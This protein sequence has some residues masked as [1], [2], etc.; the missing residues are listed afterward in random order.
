MGTVSR[1]SCLRDAMSGQGT[2]TSD[3]V[4]NAAPAS[5][6][7][8]I[9]EELRRRGEWDHLFVTHDQTPKSEDISKYYPQIQEGPRPIHEEVRGYLKMREAKLMEEL[10]RKEKG[11]EQKVS[12]YV[13]HRSKER[14][15]VNLQT[16]RIYRNRAPVVDSLRREEAIR[17]G[18]TLAAPAS[19]PLVK[20]LIG[21]GR[22]AEVELVPKVQ[23]LDEL[24]EL[25]G[26][27][28]DKVR[29]YLDANKINTF[30]HSPL[31]DDYL[32]ELR[33]LGHLR[34]DLLPHPHPHSSFDPM[35]LDNQR[36]EA[37]LKALADTGASPQKMMEVMRDLPLTHAQKA[38][39][40]KGLDVGPLKRVELLRELPYSNTREL[41]L[42]RELPL[43]PLKKL[44]FLRG[45]PIEPSKK[46]E[47]MREL[48]LPLEP[49][50]DL[51]MMQGVSGPLEA[52]ATM[53]ELNMAPERRAAL[54]GEMRMHDFVEG[55][56][57]NQFAALR[58]APIPLD[59]KLE[60]LH[61]MKLTE[62]E[63]FE[64][65]RRLGYPV[66]PSENKRDL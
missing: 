35:L 50:A 57:A 19:M 41:E 38:D 56:V 24:R 23:L 1:L 64:L 58:D 18:I 31:V 51:Q 27:G 11:L 13:H 40:I 65:N 9:E 53:D 28:P 63:R 30:T 17:R 21:E 45:L 15:S 42:L 46:V 34:E 12:D 43:D 44:E 48:G 6:S 10:W 49:S 37:M 3:I 16:G 7:V 33:V 39:F 61:E 36:S 66:D 54:M 55:E 59:K 26:W 60:I 47:L 14:S 8:S 4:A 29:S 62:E 22:R 2:T 32:K 52:M 5:R 20:D 25:R